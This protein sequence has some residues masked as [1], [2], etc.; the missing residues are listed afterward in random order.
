MRIAIESG[1]MATA[2]V[3]VADSAG[4][5]FEAANPYD[6]ARC[7]ASGDARVVDET[8]SGGGE[9]A[10]NASRL[11]YSC[12]VGDTGVRGVFGCALGL[13]GGRSSDRRGAEGGMALADCTRRTTLPPL[14]LLPTA[15]AR[16]TGET[17]VGGSVGS[18]GCDGRLAS[19]GAVGGAVGG[20]DLSAML[21]SPLEGIERMFLIADPMPRLRARVTDCLRRLG[22]EG[23]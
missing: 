23:E 6:E 19:R 16:L 2:P 8:I 20:A 10:R 11:R 18:E 17:G 9:R 22:N 14:E 13:S 7:A 15:R 12:F 5:V 4:S 3:S 21:P 1:D